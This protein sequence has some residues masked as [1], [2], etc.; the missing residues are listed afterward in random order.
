MTM[1]DQRLDREVSARL[2]RLASA[3]PDYDPTHSSSAPDEATVRQVLYDGKPA[4][5]TLECAGDEFALTTI[6]VS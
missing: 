1:D 5:V 2:A 3:A 6:A 4:A